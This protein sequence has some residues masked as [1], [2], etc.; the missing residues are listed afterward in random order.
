M[1]CEQCQELLSEFVDRELDSIISF[2]VQ[3][4][5]DQCVGCEE[6]FADFSSILSSYDDKLETFDETNLNSQAIWCRI[7]NEIETEVLPELAKIETAKQANISWFEKLYRQ[8]LRLSFSQTVSAVFF[9]ALI[10]SLL[11]IV[12]IRN[13]STTNELTANSTMSPNLVERL[14]GRIGVIETP[15][16]AREKRVKEQEATISYWNQRVETRKVQWNTHLREAFERNLKEIDQVVN[17]Y[18]VVLEENP[19][20]ELSGEMLDSALS[21][22]MELLRGFSEL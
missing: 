10:S 6:I 9:V 3:T 7:S 8:S 11:T 16:E 14:L 21:E 15:R 1:N 18:S 19:Q 5:I 17:E 4:H 22:K 12:G 20:D 13:Y 2:E